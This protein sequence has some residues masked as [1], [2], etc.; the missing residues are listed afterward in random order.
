MSRAQ[1]LSRVLRAREILEKVATADADRAHHALELARARRDAAER[2][3]VAAAEEDG[4]D[5]VGE[6]ARE[7]ERRDVLA[8]RIRVAQTVVLQSEAAERQAHSEARRARADVVRI[9]HALDRCR[10]EEAGAER[11]RENAEADAFALRS[12]GREW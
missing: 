7:A 8:G 3:L 5:T 12:F 10:R 4:G 9:E 11:R 1:R 2:A 6:R